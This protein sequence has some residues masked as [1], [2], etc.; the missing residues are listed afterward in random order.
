MTYQFT[1][2]TRTSNRLVGTVL[3]LAAATLH[4]GVMKMR[5]THQMRNL[6]DRALKDAGLTRADLDTRISPNQIRHDRSGNW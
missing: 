6:P 4:S 5:T 1:Q 2:T 3:T